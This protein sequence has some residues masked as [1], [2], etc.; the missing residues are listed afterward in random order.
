MKTTSGNT[1]STRL[2]TVQSLQEQFLVKIGVIPLQRGS[3]NRS[4]AQL[5][6]FRQVGHVTPLRLPMFGEKVQLPRLSRK[7]A[8]ASAGNRERAL[9]DCHL[10]QFDRKRRYSTPCL[11]VNASNRAFPEMDDRPIL[12]I[13]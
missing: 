7:V 8:S 13:S 6:T 9:A 3:I 2:V 1:D 4:N 12:C 10:Q 11:L 5:V